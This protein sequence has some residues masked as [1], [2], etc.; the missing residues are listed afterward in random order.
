M[1]INTGKSFYECMGMVEYCSVEDW[2]SRNYPDKKSSANKCAVAVSDMIKLFPGLT[3]QVGIANE[4]YHCWAIDALGKIIDP[5]AKQFDG[6]V[7]Y[8]R[9]I[10]NRFLRKEEIDPSSG[11]IICE[12][13]YNEESWKAEGHSYQSIGCYENKRA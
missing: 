7:N 5:T 12:D 1:G 3:V 6:D 11:H 4:V 8:T 13:P 9:V 2:I 10:A